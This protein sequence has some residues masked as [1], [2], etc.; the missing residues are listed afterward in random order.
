M[1]F[2]V[3]GRVIADVRRMQILDLLQ[4]VGS[5]T[6]TDLAS[7]FSVSE[8][9]MRRDLQLLDDEG[10]VRRVRGG[11]MIMK[12]P[13][14]LP[15]RTR[16]VENLDEKAAIAEQAVNLVTEGMS[17][18]LAPGTTAREVALRLPP[19]GLRVIT[20]SLPISQELAEGQNDFVLTGGTLRRF[21]ES[22]VG[23][24][25]VASLEAESIHMAFIGVSGV[26]IAR[27]LTLYSAEEANVARAAVRSSRVTCVLADSSKFDSD[28]GVEAV[29]LWRVHRVITD[30]G[31]PDRYREYFAD[32]DIAV[33]IVNIDQ[34]TGRPIREHIDEGGSN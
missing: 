1:R 22:L 34:Q 11:A 33:D 32:H 14:E 16:M 5:A 10:F 31:L 18:F 23:P 12:S 27:G 21:S 30:D 17:V 3:G 7:R 8:M 26:S 9:T 25:A 6:V 13:T 4:E 29:P 19:R 2:A 28:V 24:S 20:N 15:F